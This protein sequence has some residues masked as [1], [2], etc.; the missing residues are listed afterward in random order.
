MDSSE[1]GKVRE[2]GEDQQHW[3]RAAIKTGLLRLG[4]ALYGMQLRAPQVFLDSHGH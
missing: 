1:T 3:D 4:L 2:T